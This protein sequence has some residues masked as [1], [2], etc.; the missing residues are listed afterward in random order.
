VG[1]FAGELEPGQAGFLAGPAMAASDRFRGA[2]TGRGGHG[3]EPHRCPDP[4]SALAELVLGLNTFR[5]RELDQTRPSVVSVCS[6]HAGDAF[7]VI[8]VRAEFAGTARSVHADIR[9]A[10]AGR[11]GE[12]A[13]GI[14]RQHGL[15]LDYQW[16]DGYPPLVNEP[17]ATAIAAAAA[18]E[19]LG[20]DRVVAL[21]RPSMGGEDFAYYLERVPGCYWFL[22]TMAPARGIEHP[23]HSSRFDLD[24]DQLW[25]LTAVNLAAAE[26]LALEFR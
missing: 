17:R 19:I 10:L 18:A 25:A 16:I 1:S 3:S 12:I 9:A 11:I 20:P 23:N 22:N 14:A 7:N 8:P 13:A 21:T 5:A 2:F 6:V 15:G 24:E 26:R 4:V